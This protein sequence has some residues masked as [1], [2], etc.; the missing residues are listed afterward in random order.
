V[1][2]RRQDLGRSWVSTRIFPLVV[3]SRFVPGLRL[4]TY[5]SLG[6][7]R[8]PFMRFAIAAIAATLVW[9]S[10]LFF[11]SLKLGTLMMHYLGIWRWAGLVVF[12]ILLVMVG[13]FATRLY[14][15]RTSE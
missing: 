3:V 10:G 6:Y 14:N 12:L 15:K 7:L 5:T 4:P 1:P 9:T 8:A 11:V 2:P 13:R